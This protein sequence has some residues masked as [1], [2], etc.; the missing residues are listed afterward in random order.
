MSHFIVRWKHPNQGWITSTMPDRPTKEG[1]T[2]QL[3][4]DVVYFYND[5]EIQLVEVTET[6]IETRRGSSERGKAR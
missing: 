4:R 1:A 5:I 2:E 3:A 6:V